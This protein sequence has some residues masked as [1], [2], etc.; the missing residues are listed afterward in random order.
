MITKFLKYLLSEQG[1]SPLTVEAYGRDLRQWADYATG[2]GRYE[3]RPETASLNDL[4]LWL[5]DVS[6]K[7]ASP[8]TIRRKVQSLR[9]FF[10]YLMRFHGLSDNPAAELTAPRAPRNLPVYVRTEETMAMLDAEESC[11]DGSFE[12][13]RNLLIID[14]LYSTGLRCSELIGLR[15]CHVD[16]V[17]RELKVV[18][19]RNKERIVPFGYELSEMIDRYRS[20]RDEAVGFTTE[21]LFVRQDGRPLYRKMVYNVVHGAMEGRV[22]ASRLSPHVLRHSFATDMLNSG[23]ELTSVQQL[24]G[25]SSLSTTQV[26]THISFRELKQNYQLAHP[27][28]QNKGG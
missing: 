22:H 19:K 18:G 5:A 25:H 27:R 26:Y 4:R 2:G 12:S 14:L 20:L 23:A 24:L 1:L 10:N 6:R 28:A 9:G 13:A 3:L 7:G 21:F 11:G 16:T 17:K 8:R 15:D